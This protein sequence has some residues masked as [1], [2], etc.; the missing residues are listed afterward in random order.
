MTV[1]LATNA[2]VLDSP[3]TFQRAVYQIHSLGHLL[4]VVEWAFIFLPILFHGLFG[5]VI[6]RGGMVNTGSYPLVGNVRYVLQRATGVIAL[7]FILGHVFHMH[8][9]F[10]SELW[11]QS[12]V[13]PLG[14]GRFRP[15]SAPS[16]LGA[17]MQGGLVIPALYAIGLT[18]CVYHLA[19]GLWTMG[20]TWGV[21]AG[22]KAQRR[23]NWICGAAGV[24]LGILALSALYGAVTVDVQRAAEIENYMYEAKVTAHEILP[25]DQ[26]RAS[27]ASTSRGASL[28]E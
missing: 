16:T 12:V 23:A 6:I 5:L 2:S 4:L 18:A 26:K 10:H 1:H 7:I 20:I 22:P 25:N 28:V 14:G 3:A 13:E 19:N 24:V 17:A 8:G 11:L 15:F 21:W 27:A 9:W